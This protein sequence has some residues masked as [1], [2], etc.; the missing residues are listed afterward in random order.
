MRFTFLRLR[1]GRQ[2][3]Y[4]GPV[5]LRGAEL[6][7]E[8]MEVAVWR[9]VVALRNTLLAGLCDV[10][11][12]LTNR[13]YVKMKLAWKSCC[14]LWLIFTKFHQCVCVC[15]C[16]LA[17]ERDFYDTHK[18]IMH[19]VDTYKMPYQHHRN[20]FVV[21]AIFP[22]NADEIDAGSVPLCRSRTILR[23]AKASCCSMMSVR[24]CVCAATGNGWDA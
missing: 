11:I 23:N 15:M 2:S 16:V 13:L 12:N 5:H 7:M 17:L 1:D 10:F 20:I 14:E 3:I 8:P 22:A 9:G 19:A 6:A 18:H 24:A 21:T 4:H